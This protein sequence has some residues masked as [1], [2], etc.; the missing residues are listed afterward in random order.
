MLA[1]SD[2]GVDAREG[3]WYFAEPGINCRVFRKFNQA[4]GIVNICVNELNLC[5]LYI[6]SLRRQLKAARL[7]FHIMVERVVW[8]H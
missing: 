6:I 4:Y 1:H 3:Y 7:C 5:I 8:G 2:K